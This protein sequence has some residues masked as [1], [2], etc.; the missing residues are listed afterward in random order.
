MKA[1][2]A[3]SG[4][5]DRA[6]VVYANRYQFA[7][8]QIIHNGPV[9]SWMVLWCETG[10]GRCTVNGRRYAMS[11]NQFL[12]LRWNHDIRYEADAEEPFLLGGVHIIPDHRDTNGRITI[13]VSHA[14][15]SPL[16]NAP[17]RRNRA[18]PMLHGLIGGSLLHCRGLAGVVRYSVQRFLDAAPDWQIGHALALLVLDEL[19][20]IA[21][22]TATSSSQPMSAP[23]QQVLQLVQN[24][25]DRPILIDELTHLAGCSVS[26]LQRHFHQ[27]LGCSP[28]EW[29]HRCRH[30]E[31]CE[32][33]RTT[34]LRMH[35]IG[36]RVGFHDP[37][38][39][40]RWFRQRAGMTA[41][42]Y[43][44]QAGPW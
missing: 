9:Q 30:Q 7:A 25:L 5:F 22:A 19:C 21:H 34:R 14:H 2:P 29:V 44:K 28:M 32:L 27:H 11:A 16:F 37:F 26:T 40:S 33:L 24:H 42:A 10:T 38:H 23:V 8:R 13:G 35:E 4:S 41:M 3:A 15:D 1:R 18:W 36:R 6:V 43:R 17:D 12:L 20:R 31:A 39:F